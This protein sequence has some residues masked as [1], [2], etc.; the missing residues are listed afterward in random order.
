MRIISFLFDPIEAFINERFS[1]R[2]P[3]AV[4]H[5]IVITGATYVAVQRHYNNADKDFGLVRQLAQPLIWLFPTLIA[6]ALVMFGALTVTHWLDRS[7]L[8]FLVPAILILNLA[9][10]AVMNEL[11]VV[12]PSASRLR[13]LAIASQSILAVA[14]F[15]AIE[16]GL[17]LV[18]L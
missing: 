8:E 12:P 5:T 3:E 13:N 16:A 2:V 17:H 7:T 6:S 4:R 14:L 10:V 15:F 18:G 9:L 11:D 1:F